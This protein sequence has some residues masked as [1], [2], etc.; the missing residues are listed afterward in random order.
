MYFI[1]NTCIIYIYIYIYIYIICIMLISRVYVLFLKSNSPYT[2]I[3]TF[4]FVYILW[5]K[6][7][8]D[9]FVTKIGK[10]EVKWL[11]MYVYDIVNSW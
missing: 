4:L 5:G 6:T 1:Y 2:I 11:Y 10:W 7:P 8:W 3:G 9:I